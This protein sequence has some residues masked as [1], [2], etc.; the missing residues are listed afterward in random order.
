MAKIDL[1]QI[2]KFKKGFRD[3]FQTVPF[4]VPEEYLTMSQ[5]REKL[6][7]IKMSKFSEDVLFFLFYNCPGELYQM[8]AANELWVFVVPCSIESLDITEIGGIT[9]RKERG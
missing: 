7:T 5:I 9:R 4:Q 6:P 8:Q 3:S 2:F 1:T